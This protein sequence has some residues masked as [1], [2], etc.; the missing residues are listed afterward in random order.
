M[1]SRKEPGRTP[2]VFESLEKFPFPLPGADQDQFV[3]FPD[4]YLRF[5]VD[6]RD[7]IGPDRDDGTA[8]QLADP[9]IREVLARQRIRGLQ[10]KDVETLG[11]H[12]GVF[13]SQEFVK[14]S[15]PM[16]LYE[17]LA[18]GKPVVSTPIP[19][20]EIYSPIVKI[21]RNDQE[22]EEKIKECLRMKD[23]KEE[24]KKRQK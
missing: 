23:N 18:M 12:G 22:F 1:S 19:A 24:I 15:N 21:G 13:V 7:S 8:R 5:G 14:G 16:K 6:R 2:S 11:Q 3:A 10:A 4:R 9:R 20:I 17:Y